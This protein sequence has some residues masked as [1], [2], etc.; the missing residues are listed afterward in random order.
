MLSRTITSR[1]Q[2]KAFFGEVLRL[3][4]DKPMVVIVKRARKHRSLKANRLYWKW[5]SCI[6]EETGNERED[7][8]EYFKERYLD[9]TKEIFGEPVFGSTARLDSK[10]FATYMEKVRRFALELNIFLPYPED[11]GFSEFHERFDG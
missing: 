11:E 5:L 2:L 4:F 8:H 7:L 3:P 9:R 6:E 10:A 1:E